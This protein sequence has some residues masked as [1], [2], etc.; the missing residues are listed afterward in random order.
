MQYLVAIFVTLVL[1]VGSLA[2]PMTSAE[3]AS[4]FGASTCCTD[5][6]ATLRPCDTIE[7]ACFLGSVWVTSLEPPCNLSW[8]KLDYVP[9]NPNRCDG[10]LIWCGNIVDNRCSNCGCF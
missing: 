4:S 1:S 2:L 3:M 5:C 6:K 10:L 7:E 9:D 8:G